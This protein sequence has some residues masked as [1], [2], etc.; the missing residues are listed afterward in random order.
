[1]GHTRNYIKV[2][3]EFVE[4][5]NKIKEGKD[6]VNCGETIQGDYFVDINTLNTHPNLFKGASVEYL[7]V[8]YDD[9]L[10]YD[11]EGN[12]IT[13]NYVA[14]KRSFFKRIFSKERQGPISSKNNYSSNNSI[15]NKL[16]RFVKNLFK[17]K[18]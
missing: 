2:S 17:L 1:M 5:Y 18:K 6:I 14:P 16:W 12:I 3:K 9:I 11:E 8:D 7:A 4:K 10:M 15:F 13:P